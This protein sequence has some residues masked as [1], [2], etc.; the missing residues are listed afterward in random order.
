MTKADAFYFTQCGEKKEEESITS[1]EELPN[2]Q[3]V[4]ELAEFITKYSYDND[5]GIQLLTDNET[6][7]SFVNN[8]GSSDNEEKLWDDDQ[9]EKGPSNEVA[10]HCLETAMK[11]LEQ[12]EEC[13]TVQLLSLN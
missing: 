4:S 11:W 3:F 2:S 9:V 10:F 8:Q 1:S 6:N 12:Q 5:P 13:N 7:E